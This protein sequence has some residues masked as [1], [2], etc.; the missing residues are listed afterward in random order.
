[1]NQF[2]SSLFLLS[3]AGA[4]AQAEPPPAPFTAARFREH[5]AYLA[6][7]ELAG[8]DVASPGSAKAVDYLIR[9]LKACGADGLA[10]RNEWVQPFPFATTVKTSVKSSLTTAGVSLELGQDFAP[11]P[12]SPDGAWEGE[13]VF[14]GYGLSAPEHG[15]DD[16]AGVT[17]QGKVAVALGNPS[18]PL[19]DAGLGVYADRERQW[20]ECE[21]RGASA[22]L[23]VAPLRTEWHVRGPIQVRKVPCILVSRKTLGR[24]LPAREGQADPVAAVEAALT[25]GG[26]ATPQSRPL[27]QKAQGVV[28][29]QRDV[30]QGRNVLAVVPGK[31]ELARDAVVVSAHH[32]HLGVDPELIKAGKDG[33]Y[34]GADDNASGCAALLLLAEALRADRDRLPASYR[35]VVF[36]SFDA[37]ERGLVGS[38][39]YV[40]HPLWP[41]ERTSA[42]VNFDMVGRLN[43]GKLTALDSLSNPFLA[44]RITALAADCGLRVETRLGGARRGDN[45]SFLDREIP[46]VHFNTGLH[47]DYHQVS[48]EVSR[49]DAA[50]GARVAW[51]AYRLLRETM[52]TPGRLRYTRPPPQFDVERILRL[53]ARLGILPELNTQPGRYPLVRAVVPGSLAA[54][55]GLKAGDEITSVNGKRLQGLEEAGIAFAEIRLKD[56]VQVSVR[57]GGKTVDVTLPPEAFKDFTGPEVRSLGNDLFEVHFRFKPPGKAM[58]VALAGTFNDWSLKAQQ[59]EGPDKQGFYATK[60]RLKRGTYEYKFVI[61]GKTWVADPTNFYTIGAQGNSLLTV[62]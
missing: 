26:K 32:D 46:A 18:K 3:C 61:D 39:Y 6:S 50:G 37:E 40:S 48:D 45:A 16:F 15:Y 5:V 14:V 41:L 58:S 62:E 12:Q 8:R 22:L 49:I 34:N 20:S 23:V 44:E 60:L 9:Q 52:T 51:L 57:R 59:L 17:L 55:Y 56:G 29:L 7:D 24:L 2:L 53:V 19:T 38:R 4:A 25:P 30:T 27:N 21:R 36:A 13:L 47:A 10:P 31:G 1:M 11:A 33:I 54:R 42:N 43:Q 35:S 28:Q